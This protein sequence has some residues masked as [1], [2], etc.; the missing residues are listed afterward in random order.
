MDGPVWEAG[1]NTLEAG[2]GKVRQQWPAILEILSSDYFFETRAP[3]LSGWSCGQHAAHL[4]LVTSWI[5]AELEANLDDAGR[6]T[7][8]SANEIGLRVLAAGRIPKGSAQTPP[9]GRP[10]GRGRAALVDVLTGA[11][12]VWSR[13]EERAPE[14]AACA[15]RVGHPV[16]GA[17]NSVEWVRFSALHTAHHL[18]IVRDVR[19][20]ALGGASED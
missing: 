13:L 11:R 12:A 1:P 8:G 6:S 14:L 16:L 17:L 2:F 10:D 9:Q 18:A 15:A 3:G 4:A 19:R 7:D 20:E 5:A